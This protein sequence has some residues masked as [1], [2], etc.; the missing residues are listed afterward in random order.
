MKN[1]QLGVL[2]ATLLLV[3]L[4]SVR[5]DT[6]YSVSNQR[7]GDEKAI[8]TIRSQ[9]ARINRDLHMCRQIKR[10]I[11]GYSTEGGEL[12]SYFFH[13]SICKAVALLGHEKGQISREYYFW[14]DRLFFVLE[15]WSRYNRRI[16]SEDPSPVRVVDK[17]EARFYFLNGSL[18][19]WLDGKQENPIMSS[20]AKQ[21]E[22]ELLDTAKEFSDMSEAMIVNPRPL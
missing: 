1:D 11:D 6:A 15:V 18:I 4:W 13:S 21:R 16:G 8:E 2:L 22:S 12:T 10:E 19:R 7:S 20:D 9:Y 3:T 17:T 14:N 5:G